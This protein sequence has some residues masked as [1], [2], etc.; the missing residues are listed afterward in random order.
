M[1]LSHLLPQDLP[2]ARI[3]TYGYNSYLAEDAST[4]RIRDFAKGLLNDL[5]DYRTKEV[6]VDADTL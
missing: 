5:D 1:W 2:S 6:Y 4:G 3:M